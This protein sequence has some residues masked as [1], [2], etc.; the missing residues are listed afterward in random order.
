MRAL[1][2]ITSVSMAYF[3]AYLLGSFFSASFDI[4]EW[5]EGTRFFIAVVG[6]GVAAITIFTILFEY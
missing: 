2:I 5:Y 1:K 6:S 3:I 4:G